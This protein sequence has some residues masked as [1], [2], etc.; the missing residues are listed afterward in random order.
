MIAAW[1]ARISRVPGVGRCV[2]AKAASTEKPG[3]VTF[4]E[5]RYWDT[6]GG[7][8]LCPARAWYTV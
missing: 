1:A 4:T 5:S 7:G 6:D 2:R 8:T 3:K